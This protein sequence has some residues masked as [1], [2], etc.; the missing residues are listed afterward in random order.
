MSNTAVKEVK[1]VLPPIPPIENTRCSPAN[2]KQKE[3]PLFDD[4]QQFVVTVVASHVGVGWIT[5]RQLFEVIA[6]YDGW[7]TGQKTTF[8][9]LFSRLIE[10]ELLEVRGPKKGLEYRITVSAAIKYLEWTEE[11]ARD[12]GLSGTAE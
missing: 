2:R 3:L 5:P 12:L 11:Q 1:K 8:L 6:K 7:N 10:L 9:P 4:V